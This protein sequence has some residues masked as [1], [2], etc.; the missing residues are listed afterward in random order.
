MGSTWLIFY[1][2]VHL[3]R[4]R[5]PY[6]RFV[7][8]TTTKMHQEIVVLDPVTARE[9]QPGEQP[10][11]VGYGGR[12]ARLC[13]AGRL[14][15]LGCAGLARSH[16]G[17]CGGEVGLSSLELQTAGS[18]GVRHR[19]LPPPSP[20]PEPPRPPRW[21]GPPMGVKRRRLGV[22][23][24][25]GRLANELRLIALQRQRA[26]ARAHVPRG[27]CGPAPAHPAP[28]GFVRWWERVGEGDGKRKVSTAQPRRAL[29]VAPPPAQPSASPVGEESC[30]S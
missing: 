3:P 16:V 11:R 7:I 21:A 17:E 19:L 2:P 22:S 28:A 12:A 27:L 30:G 18:L 6:S 1:S 20:T 24:R 25:S 23:L 4:L 29:A 8:R 14:S 15:G 9:N 10:G 5:K 26:A 13:G